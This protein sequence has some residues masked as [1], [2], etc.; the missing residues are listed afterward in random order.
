MNKYEELMNI[1]SFSFILLEKQK[2]LNLHEGQ[3]MWNDVI[4]YKH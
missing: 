1:C 4:R 3:E 2:V